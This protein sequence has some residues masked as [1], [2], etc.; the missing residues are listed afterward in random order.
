MLTMMKKVKMTVM[1]LVTDRMMLEVYPEPPDLHYN[2]D[3]LT[4]NKP[5]RLR[6]VDMKAYKCI[7][8]GVMRTFRL[9]WI[10]NGG[11]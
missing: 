5:Y 11:V 4:L 3:N 2:E 1:I 6:T 10:E 7:F 9:H 8:K